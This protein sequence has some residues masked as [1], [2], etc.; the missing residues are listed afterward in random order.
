MKL[1]DCFIGQIVRCVDRPRKIG[2]I[3][4]L[5]VNSLRDVI[6]VV[7]WADDSLCANNPY[8]IHPSNVQPLK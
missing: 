7:K 3:I 1:E 6:L 5:D 8:G 2:Y 4:D